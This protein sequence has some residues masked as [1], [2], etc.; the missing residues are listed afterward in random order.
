[1]PR[2]PV[3]CLEA[4]G[5]GISMEDGWGWKYLCT[6]ADWAVQ[7]VWVESETMER[8]VMELLDE[9]A[10]FKLQQQFQA[11]TFAKTAEYQQLA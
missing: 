1:M 3:T 8:F 5:I 11:I 4:I 10:A 9:M 7:G 6:L 2:T